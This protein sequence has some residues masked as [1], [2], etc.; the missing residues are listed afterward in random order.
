MSEETAT[1][2][3]AGT[4][5]VD[6]AVKPGVQFEAITTQD[7]LD[8]IVTNRLSRER[9]KYADYDA[10]KERAAKW[11]EAEEAN[12]TELQKVLERAEQAEAAVVAAK[13]DAILARY[14][15][16]DEYQDLITASDPEGM[17]AQAQKLQ[18][19]TK[20][21]GPI[22]PTQGMQPKESPGPDDWIRAGFS[23]R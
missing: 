4:E 20:Q 5:T 7:E 11:D 15:V 1:T 6:Q 18:G 12:K 9:A 23:R 21:M 10:L 13:R 16:P 3:E 19:L 22:I 2:A 17:E 8:R 14:Q